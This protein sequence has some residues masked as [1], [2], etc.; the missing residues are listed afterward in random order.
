MDTDFKSLKSR[1]E[2]LIENTDKVGKEAASFSVAKSEL[3]SIAQDLHKISSDLSTAIHAAEK[4]LEQVETVAVSSTIESMKNSAE[5]FTKTGEK[6]LSTLN[7][8]IEESTKVL[9]HK[10]DALSSDLRKK[11]FIIGGIA[12]LIAIIALICS[13]I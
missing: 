10:S 9:Q 6:L 2:E 1:I 12:I 4:V 3:V 7:S 8:K 13:L 5:N 11:M